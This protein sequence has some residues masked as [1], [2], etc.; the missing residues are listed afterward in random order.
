VAVSE[1]VFRCRDLA[2]VRE[3]FV[4]AW[5]AARGYD[6]P[7]EIVLRLLKDKRTVEQ[8]RRM[9]KLLREVAA[10]V[11]VDVDGKQRQFADKVWHVYF[12]EQFI[13]AE[14][15]E[16]PDGSVKRDPISTTKLDVEAMTEYMN[17]IEQWCV[18]QG[19]PV[20]EAA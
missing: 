9:W 4:L 8:N 15:T 1:R 6:R 10:T 11:W 20:M 3:A 2:K 5:N 17:R 19:F 18:E 12:R 16:M 14:E 13:G 7:F